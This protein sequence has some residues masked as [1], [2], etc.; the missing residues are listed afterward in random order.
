MA[1]WEPFTEPARRAIV[2]AQDLAQRLDSAIIDAEHILAGIVAV[3]RSPAADALASFGVTPERMQ[4]AAERRIPR[5]TGA[6]HEMVFTPRAKRVIEHAF[7][8][9][10][11]LGN[12]YIG[13]EH[14]L[15][16]YVAECGANSELLRDLQLDGGAVRAKILELIHPRE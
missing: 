5:G 13:S 1:M 2:A 4:E 3:G 14:L 7:G 8:E 10:R 12:N 9:A 15:L 16:A 6:A 11:A